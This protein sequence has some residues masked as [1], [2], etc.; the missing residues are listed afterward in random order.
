MIRPVD[1]KALK[2]YKIWIKYSDGMQGEVDLSDFAGKGV[3]KF[4]DHNCNFTDVSLGGSGEIQ[5][6]DKIDLCPDMIY[7]RLTGKK[8]EELFP[9][10]R[11]ESINA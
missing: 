10:L 1:I 6:S 9:K 3:F 11:N 4:W 7:M 5:W 2:K 8:A